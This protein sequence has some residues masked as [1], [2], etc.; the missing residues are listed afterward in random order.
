[1]TDFRNGVRRCRTGEFLSW[2]HY[3]HFPATATF[4]PDVLILGKAMQLA[5]IATKKVPAS[6]GTIDNGVTVKLPGGFSLSPD[7]EE[8]T[9]TTAGIRRERMRYV[10][11]FLRGKVPV[12]AMGEDGVARPTNPPVYFNFREEARAMHAAVESALK[13]HWREES[14]L[15]NGDVWGCGLVWFAK[16]DVYEEVAWKG[17]IFS[18]LDEEPVTRCLLPVRPVERLE[19]FLSEQFSRFSR[20]AKKRKRDKE[21]SPA[22]VGPSE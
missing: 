4:A 22:P 3:T 8:A 1:M 18:V 17:A 19:L 10:L 2:Q 12:L 9:T 7:G 20:G 13:A 15:K 5:C 16:Q 21:I 6:T 14:F 11:N